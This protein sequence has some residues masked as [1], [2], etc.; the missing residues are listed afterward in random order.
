MQ[1]VGTSQNTHFLHMPESH[2]HSLR[3]HCCSPQCEREIICLLFSDHDLLVPPRAAGVTR[4]LSFC[5][6]CNV[7][8]PQTWLHVGSFTCLNLVHYVVCTHKA[9]YFL[10]S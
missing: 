5:S 4:A 9:P 1:L 10:C 8:T 7:A 3:M 6:H 2:C